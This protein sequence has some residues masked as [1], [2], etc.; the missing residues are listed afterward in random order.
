MPVFTKEALARRSD[1]FRYCHFLITSVRFMRFAVWKDQGEPNPFVSPTYRH[2]G[3]H[4]AE[5]SA[6]FSDSRNNVSHF[7]P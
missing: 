5:F 7:A 6:I 2:K 3:S 4:R 1:A